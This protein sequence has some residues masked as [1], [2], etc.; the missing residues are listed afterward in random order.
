MFIGHFALGLASKKFRSA[1][2]LALT[3]IAVQFLDLI[4]PLFVLSGIES[5]HIEAGNTKLTPLNFSFY[6]Y[7]HSLLMAFLWGLLMGLTYFF[8]TKNKR[9]S[10][11]LTMLVI[12]HWLLDFI[13]HRPDLPL[14]PF[15]GP[16]AGL[17]LWNY[18]VIET[19]FEVG[20]FIVGSMLYYKHCK[21]RKKKAFGLLVGLFLIIH[22]MNIFGPPPPSEPAV[23]WA[24]NLSWLFVLWA[25]WIERRTA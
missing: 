20:I 14:S 18:P 13:S 11:L 9:G 24:A 8:A 23:A 3:F 21:P 16:K 17:G 7:S 5:F 25:W 19:L 6:P 2:S 4:W 10:F 22:L 1:P 12:S 15:G